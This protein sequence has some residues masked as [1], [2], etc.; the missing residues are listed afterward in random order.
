M[1]ALKRVVHLIQEKYY[2]EK[3]KKFLRSIQ[4][5]RKIPHVYSS[6]YTMHELSVGTKSLARF[7]DGEFVWMMQQSKGSFEK[8]SPELA[9]KLLWVLRSS[10]PDM[11]ICIPDVFS[12]LNRF[13]TTSRLYWERELSIQ[14]LSWVKFLDS[15]RYYY[16]TQV[17][18]P[19]MD[20]KEKTSSKNIFEGFQKIWR[21]RNVLIVEGSMTRF[22]IG[23]D[24]LSN[25]KS[26]YRVLCP[27]TN[28]FEK[29]SEILQ[30]VL[31]RCRAL[32]NV[33]VLIALGPTATVLA[34]DLHTNYGIQALDIGH[35]DIEYSWF[36]K[37][38]TEKVAVT[39]KY[40]NESKKR[41]S[42]SS[43][44]DANSEKQYRSQIIDQI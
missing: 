34:Y 39:G 32:D 29:Y 40:V 43:E 8:N 16:D 30:T 1:K 24:L 18:R 37:R 19:Y 17:T 10:D 5:S 14:G 31:E 9:E 28:A 13:N 42:D 36:L 6:E 7:G 35:L 22:G 2:R 26:I 25:A 23:N 3:Y 15:K 27:A 33:L 20:M 21:N 4:V 38:A 12:E 41:Y 44:L 11:L